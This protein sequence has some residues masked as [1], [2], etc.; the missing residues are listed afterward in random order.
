MIFEGLINKLIMSTIKKKLKER[1]M[2]KLWELFNGKKAIIGTIC[3]YVAV[4]FIDGFLFNNLNYRPEWLS[5]I[6]Q[7]L[8]WVGG[9]LV[10]GGL[11]HKAVKAVKAAN[12]K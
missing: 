9:I 3:L 7:L 4:Y 6:Y 12:E 8:M 11:A 2:L 10:P 1:G 5:F